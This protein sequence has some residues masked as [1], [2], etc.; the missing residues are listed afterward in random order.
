[1]YYKTIKIGSQCWMAENLKIG[2]TIDGSTKQTNNNI[3][4]KYCYDNN[5][6]NCKI[7]GGLYQWDEMMQYVNSEKT[8]GICPDGWHIPNQDEW[9][10][11][12]INLGGES[13][14]GGKM[15]EKGLNHWKT[16][17]NG[18]TDESG[19]NGLPGGYRMSYDYF[20]DIG[21][22][23]IFWSSS[24]FSIYYSWYVCLDYSNSRITSDNL[25]GRT[26]AFSVRCIRN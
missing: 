10:I 14:A 7:Y 6:N 12:T 21:N 2:K 5:T 9:T 19:F 18:A 4:E 13:I 17:N 16:P 26:C 24:E 15:K 3:I 8:Q 1:M 25:N 20:Y 23:S 11:L 22:Y